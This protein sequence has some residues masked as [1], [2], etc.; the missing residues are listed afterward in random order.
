MTL[1]TVKDEHPASV[2]AAVQEIF[3]QWLDAFK[4]ILSVDVAGELGSDN[5][6][7]L[8][9]RV[10]IFNV[11][12]SFQLSCTLTDTCRVAVP[13]DYPQQLPVD[14]QAAPSHLP[15]SQHGAPHLSVPRLRRLLPLLLCRSLRPPKRRGGLGRSLGSPRTRRYR[16]R[17]CHASR[18][19]EGGPRHICAR[20]WA[21]WTDVGGCSAVCDEIC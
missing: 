4:Q 5:W 12:A 17:L 10:A 1:F 15:D 18:S 14:P 7:I 6:E 20:G 9:I 3:P 21:A 8:A 16:A 13:R 11:C 2:K 19:Q